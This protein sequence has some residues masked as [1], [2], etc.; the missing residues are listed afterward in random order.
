MQK[1]KPIADR[2]DA[3]L[4]DALP[5]SNRQRF[6]RNLQMIVGKLGAG[7]ASGGKSRV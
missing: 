7:E 6:V 2:V 1:A 4:L 3:R 5:A